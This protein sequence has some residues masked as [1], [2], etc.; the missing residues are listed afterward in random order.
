MEI[1]R[2]W[3]KIIGIVLLLVGIAGF[4]APGGMLLGFQVNMLHNVVHLITGAIFAWAGFSA[5]APTKKINLIFGIIYLLIAILGFVPGVDVMLNSLLA[6][7]MADHILHLAIGVI[8]V[9][10]GWKAD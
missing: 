1:N 2:T 10:I 5:S 9:A 3:A 8:S 4:F 6:T 7:N